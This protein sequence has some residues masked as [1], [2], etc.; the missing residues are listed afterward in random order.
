M[1]VASN[2][3]RLSTLVL[4]TIAMFDLVSTLMWMNM[5]GR[6]G[7]PIFAALA[8]KGSI[9][10]VLGK[11]LFLAIPIA[12]IEWARKKRPLSAEIGTWVAASAYA[13]LWIKHIVSM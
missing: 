6:E 13:F 12:V 11:L 9:V 1:K 3:V 4:V 8:S 5:G 7:N 2:R 10:F